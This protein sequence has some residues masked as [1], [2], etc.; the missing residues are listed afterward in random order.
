MKNLYITAIV[1]LGALPVAASESLHFRII[2]SST[3]AFTQA[4]TDGVLSWS[5]TSTGTLE[6]LQRIEGMTQSGWQDYVLIP[7]TSAT[8]SVKVFEPHSPEDM[9]FIPAGSFAM[10]GETNLYPVDEYG[11]DALPQHTVFVGGILMDK[12]EVTLALWHAVKN[13]NGGNGY[14][15]RNSG[16][17]KYLT[18]PVQSIDWYDAVKWCNARSERDGLTPVYYTNPGFTTLYKTGDLSPSV[19][20]SASGYRLP[21]EAEWEKAA[22]GGQARNRFPWSNYSNNISHLKANYYGDTGH[23]YDLSSGFHPDY[24]TGGFPYTSPVGSFI[25]NEYGLYDMSG[26]VW[27]WCWDW[28]DSS[29]Y[30]ISPDSNPTGPDGPLLGRVQRGGSYFYNGHDARIAYRSHDYPP[31]YGSTDLGFRCVRRP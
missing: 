16:S 28:Y 31:N 22:R 18:H 1:L 11:F 20:W 2:S 12:H 23:S 6:Q 19:D 9:A 17:G 15:Y 30:E 8:M 21:T 3:T 29:Y 24:S 25:P 10:G 27:E 7:A 13:H 26:N 4:S 5:N 14:D